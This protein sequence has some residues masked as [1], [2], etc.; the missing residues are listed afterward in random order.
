MDP[1]TS[2]SELVNPENKSISS[3]D[4]NNFDTVA[5]E[6]AEAMVGISE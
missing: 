3:T 4:C 1:L 5:S 2:P 6:L